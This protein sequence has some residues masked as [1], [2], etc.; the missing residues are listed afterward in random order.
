[1]LIKVVLGVLCQGLVVTAFGGTTIEN[2]DKNDH[3]ADKLV[4]VGKAGSEITII[5]D[6]DSAS[7]LV[8]LSSLFSK[9]LEKRKETYKGDEDDI[10]ESGLG[11]KKNW[12]R[13]QT[14]RRAEKAKRRRRGSNKTIAPRNDKVLQKITNIGLILWS[15]LYIYFYF[16]HEVDIVCFVGLHIR[17]VILSISG[18]VDSMCQA[19]TNWLWPAASNALPAKEMLICTLEKCYNFDEIA[20]ALRKIF[21]TY[22]NGNEACGLHTMACIKAII[23]S[24]MGGISGSGTWSILAFT[25]EQAVLAALYGLFGTMEHLAS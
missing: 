24:S 25:S 19:V 21:S 20:G 4:N 6:V 13:D 8:F 18:G 9:K 3:L 11:K 5:D 12:K 17:Q 10:P 22:S 2:D 14:I 1:M 16:I 23:D 15:F 7:P